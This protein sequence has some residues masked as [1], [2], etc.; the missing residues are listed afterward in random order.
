MLHDLKLMMFEVNNILSNLVK[1]RHTEKIP[2]WS[3]G[4]HLLKKGKLIENKFNSKLF[5][6]TY[7]KINNK[8][9]NSITVHNILKDGKHQ[10]TFGIC[11]YVSKC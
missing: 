1:W 5:V 10:Y 4:L 7:L 3:L 8:F 11:P 2:A 9:N 6:Q